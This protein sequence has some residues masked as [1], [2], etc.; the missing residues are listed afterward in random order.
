MSPRLWRVLHR[1]VDQLADPGHAGWQAGGSALRAT[2]RRQR[3][4][5]LRSCESTERMHAL[6]TFAGHVRQ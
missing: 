4:R 3:L 5:D 1:A 6:E 2:D